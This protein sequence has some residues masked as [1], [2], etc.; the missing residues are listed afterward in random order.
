MNETDRVNYI[1][2]LVFDTDSKQK[3]RPIIVKFKSWESQ[4]VF[5]KAFPR[6]FVNTRKKPGPKSFSILLDIT[7]RPYILLTKVKILVK[8]NLSVA[9]GFC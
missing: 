5:Y 8:D 3:F 9:Y 1:G 4:T 2:N 7:K 6:N